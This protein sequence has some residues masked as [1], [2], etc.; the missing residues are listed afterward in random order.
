MSLP[1]VACRSLLAVSGM[2]FMAAT[3]LY[4]RAASLPSWIEFICLRSAA[5]GKGSSLCLLARRCI[6]PKSSLCGKWQMRSWTISLSKVAM[7]RA[8]LQVKQQH[9]GQWIKYKPPI[10]WWWRWRSLS[11][12]L[13]IAK[14]MNSSFNLLARPTCPIVGSRW[15]RTVGNGLGGGGFSY[16]HG[17]RILY[18]PAFLGGLSRNLVYRWGGGSSETKEPKFKNFVYFEQ[19]IVK[20]TQFEQKLIALLSK[21]IFRWVGNSAKKTW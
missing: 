10:D 5:V 20:S 19:I 13:N 12:I 9:H 21:L 17:I 3:S 1:S 18:V 4:P 6:L 2:Q 7:Q 14:V 15:A 11:S 16:W 8:S